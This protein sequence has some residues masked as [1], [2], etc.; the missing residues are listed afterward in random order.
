MV[1]C[2]LCWVPFGFSSEPF[3]WE[4]STF[5]IDTNSPVMKGENCVN[6][7]I[8][9]IPVNTIDQ[10]A[11]AEIRHGIVTDGPFKLPTGYKLGSMVVYLVS[12]GAKLKKSLILHLP[13]WLNSVSD[14]KKLVKCVWAP[15]GLQTVKKEY[16][17]SFLNE[18]SYRITQ[19]AAEIHVDGVNT[20]FAIAY[21]AGV[22]T[23][24]QYQVFDEET[25]EMS[26]QT[27]DVRIYITFFC[28]TWKKVSMF[29]IIHS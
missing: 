7:T 28:H 26:Q 27:K 19:T 21:E 11:K 18:K 24:Y 9:E 2:D 29:S 20:L 3:G 23:R 8:I 12:G 13:H 16:S 1:L 15:H 14:T 10:N 6:Q 22:K 4:G 5:N 25:S 17:F